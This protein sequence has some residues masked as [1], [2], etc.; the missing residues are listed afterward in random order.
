MAY[1]PA[2]DADQCAFDATESGDG[3]TRAAAQGL[4]NVLRQ[5]AA[6]ADLIEA[7][8]R[9]TRTPFTHV[10]RSRPDALWYLP[11]APACAW[12]ARGWRFHD[13]AF[14]FSRRSLDAV[15]RA[16]S[17]A[18][19]AACEATPAAT[20]FLGTEKA[21]FHWMA[22]AEPK[23][24]PLSLYIVRATAGVLEMNDYA[25]QACAS[26]WGCETCAGFLLGARVNETEPRV[27]RSR[28]FPGPRQGERTAT[29]GPDSPRDETRV[30]HKAA[31]APC[32]RHYR[33]KVKR[34][35]EAQE[36]EREQLFAG[37]R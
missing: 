8:E 10:V 5:D 37:A 32:E 33:E 28:G 36:P 17:R 13:W 18:F 19:A 3:Y 35:R 15:L 26:R 6:C 22:G 30:P 16:P 9:E 7:R 23:A 1:E 29:R 2:A 12:P 11:A 25:G 31:R 24:W 14:L 34:L 27:R 21:R 20:P 4:A